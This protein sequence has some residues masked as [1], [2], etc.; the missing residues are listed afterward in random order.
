MYPADT[1]PW[2]PAPQI[3]VYRVGSWEK[4][5]RRV[6][7]NPDWRYTAKLS[8]MVLA[9]PGL[10]LLVLI[11]SL[12]V[13][14]YSDGPAGHSHM[15]SALSRPD[16]A[17]PQI[18][19]G[20]GSERG[21]IPGTGATET[22][23]SRL[24]FPEG[25]TSVSVPLERGG[26]RLYVPAKING[27]ELCY[28]QVDT[29]AARSFVDRSL[30]ERLCPHM[31][32]SQAGIMFGFRD[33]E[34]DGIDFPDQWKM[35]GVTGKTHYVSHWQVSSIDVGG[36]VMK[37][38]EM[39]AA[40]LGEKETRIGRL[41]IGLLGCD[42]L[43]QAPFTLDYETP[44]IIFHNPARFS[45]PADALEVQVELR[46]G[47]PTTIA[48]FGGER[49]VRC[50][51]DTGADGTLVLKE[52]LHKENL[53][54]FQD[55]GRS[56]LYG[57]VV[58]YTRGR[59]R[60]CS[61]ISIMGRTFNEVEADFP[62]GCPENIIGAAC[63]KEFELTFD[64]ARRRVWAKPR[65][66]SRLKERLAKGV[67]ANKGDFLGYTPLHLAASEGRADDVHLLLAS[68]Y[69]V[70]AR[71]VRGCTPLH[72]ASRARRTEVLD[73]LLS[74]GAD[75]KVCDHF[76]RTALMCAAEQGNASVIEA[77]VAKGADVNAEDWRG[78]TALM[79][80]AD[81][82]S[83]GAVKALLRLKA[84]PRKRTGAYTVLAVAARSGDAET[85]EALVAAGADVNE[86]SEGSPTALM[87][88]AKEGHVEAVKV[89]L[90]LNADPR[91]RTAF[92]TTALML[93]VRARSREIVE[94]LVAAGADVSAKDE[95]AMTPVELARI[96]R[97]DAIVEVLKKA[98]A[99][100]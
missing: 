36:V 88:A 19:E 85:I 17:D 34:D 69:P 38:V 23:A 58:G 78:W 61:S 16:R 4:L 26:D 80:A 52:P 18:P 28:L 24:R 51:L 7:L 6:F 13:F 54:L 10:A 79:W 93:A 32:R 72:M 49:E 25:R 35:I 20:G 15:A 53:D 39:G 77:L 21:P 63:L 30:A 57:G 5:Q 95:M 48:K 84:D 64:W 45:P 37:D 55:G 3:P 75:T 50:L 99:K 98:G 73:A 66:L 12:V 42:F 27:D 87:W 11:A 89:L 31:R 2:G 70:N 76:G 90:K 91:A 33:D 8:I 74:S 40:P 100:E 44:A 22:S 14:H 46:H 47:L 67:D 65:P 94:A 83:A 96:L 62:E 56:K 68:G 1:S 86:Q 97:E 9:A 59:V 81:R 60:T 29:G 92:G 41:R 82:S 43:A 71:D